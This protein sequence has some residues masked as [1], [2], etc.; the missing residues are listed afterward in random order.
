MEVKSPV[1]GVVSALSPSAV[2]PD[3]PGNPGEAT[4]TLT[5][6]VNYSNGSTATVSASGVTIQAILPSEVNYKFGSLTVDGVARTDTV[7]GDNAYYDS[8]SR[9]VV[10]TFP[11]LAIGASGTIQFQGI[12]K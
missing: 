6:T 4:S 7:D 11:S 10:V 5:F 3:D 9:M 2:N 1:L 12:V 8:V